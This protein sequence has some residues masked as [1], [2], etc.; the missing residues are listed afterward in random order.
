M[1][2]RVEK[3]VQGKRTQDGTGVSLVRVLGHETT[4]VY[5]PFLM[6]DAFDSTNPKDYVK[7]FPM[8]PH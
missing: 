1:L 2:R 8:H 7:G 5:D 3:Q 6:L 4:N